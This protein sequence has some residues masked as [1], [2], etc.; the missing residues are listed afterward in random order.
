MRVAIV[1]NKSWNI[2]NYRKGLLLT[3]V[4][5]GFSVLAIAPDDEYEKELLALGVQLTVSKF[6]Q[7]AKNPF[8]ELLGLSRFTT[9]IFKIRPSAIVSFTIKPNLYC[10]VCA[11]LFRIPLVTVVTGLSQQVLG[12]TWY[13]KILRAIYIAVLKN[14]SY[15]I[16]Q[17][18][19]DLA[20]YESFVGEFKRNAV[21]LGSGVNL[22]KFS[23]AKL[24]TGDK[25]IFL[26]VSR[27]LREKGIFDFAMAARH[28]RER[29]PG[30]EAEFRLLGAN[31]GGQP[32]LIP[33]AQ[34]KALAA[35]Y[36]ILIL[37]FKKDVRPEIVEAHCMVLASH[38]EGMSRALLEGA[39]MGRPLIVTDIPGCRELVDQGINGFTC[40]VNNYRSLTD[41][42]TRFARLT[43]DEREAL[44]KRSREKVVHSFDERTLWDS[45][46]QIIERLVPT[47]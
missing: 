35:D 11:A 36:G 8:F 30:V 5:R 15:V 18:W 13:N 47:A 29:N 43:P 27:F 4:E 33:D 25:L 31:F 37:P 22:E 16:F 17:N 24:P 9:T 28:F 12:E 42:M 32:G 34:L 19:A 46:A 38:R 6:K 41:A 26:C 14:S 23:E 40:Q 2:I 20:W 45:Y 44:G 1:S 3:L 39:A 21:N 7:G 10:F